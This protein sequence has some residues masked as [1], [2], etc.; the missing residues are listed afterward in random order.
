[1][2]CIIS[3]RTSNHIMIPLVS[4]KP[5]YLCAQTLGIYMKVLKQIWTRLLKFLLSKRV[6]FCK[7]TLKKV[8]CGFSFTKPLQKECNPSKN[9]SKRVKYHSFKELNAGQLTLF[10]VV[11]H[12][13]LW[14]S[15]ISLFWSGFEEGFT[16]FWVVW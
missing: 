10:R 16:L 13:T 2:V 12:L 7:T 6:K 8:K 1:M 14:K 5:Y 3:N 9:Q 11:L 15:G 4:K